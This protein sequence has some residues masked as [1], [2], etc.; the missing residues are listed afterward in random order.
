M[1][2]ISNCTPKP[3]FFIVFEGIDGVGKT[4]QARLLCQR[5]EAEGLAP[6][7]IK[8]PTEGPWGLK[9]RNMAQNG[10]QGVSLAEELS[11]FVKDRAEDVALNIKPALEAGR[12]VI[13]DRYF[14]SNLAYQAALGADIDEIRALNEG[15]PI[16]E[17]VFVLEL[18]V[19]DSQGRITNGRGETP[20]PTFE[21]AGFL[22]KVDA[23][24]KTLPDKN[25]VRLA[26]AQSPEILARI[27]WEKVAKKF[28]SA[29]NF[30]DRKFDKKHCAGNDK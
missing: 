27:I 18:A 26:A 29:C 14:Y 6:L 17:I 9:I 15:F 20:N 19:E 1:N 21:N 30:S 23:I 24:F 10:R 22:E 5:L 7:Y 2:P 25:L 11:W 4:T 28:L 16:P 12:P 13:A 8:E 3:A